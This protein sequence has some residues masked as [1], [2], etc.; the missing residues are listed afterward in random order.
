MGCD[1]WFN[2]GDFSLEAV[3]WFHPNVLFLHFLTNTAMF[4]EQLLLDYLI[5]D[6]TS[7]LQYLYR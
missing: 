7:F 2:D 4:D 6:E 1:R 3:S 5:S